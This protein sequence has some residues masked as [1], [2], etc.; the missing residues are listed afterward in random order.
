MPMSNRPSKSRARNL[1]YS[2]EVGR[3]CPDCGQAV[4][5]CTCKATTAVVGGDGVVRL[6][7]E[8]KGR[9]GKGVTLVKGLPLAGDELAGLAKKLKSAC[10]VGGSI[11]SGV[12]ELQTAER[13]KIKILLE[14]A[15]FTVKIAGG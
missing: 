10:G 12:I 1:V 15:G 4:R 6:F 5:D 2:T 7:R 14:N 9:K 13:E 11:K 8:T 3:A